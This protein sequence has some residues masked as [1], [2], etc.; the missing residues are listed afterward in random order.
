MTSMQS[1]TGLSAI[2]TGFSESIIAPSLDPVDI[3]TTYLE[4]WVNKVGGELTDQILHQFANLK[5]QTPS[6]SDQEIGEQM[7][8]DDRGEA[9]VMACRQ[10]IFLWYMGAWP[11]VIEDD[12]PA[13]TTRGS[14]PY[15]TISSASYTSGLVWQVMQSHAMG[16]SKSRYGYWAEQPA[17]LSAYTGNNDD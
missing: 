9:F 3:K 6:L 14:T 15:D 8:D 2:L 7:L 4:T 11:D 5:T 10:L 16:D 17:P 1:F 12:N 13:S